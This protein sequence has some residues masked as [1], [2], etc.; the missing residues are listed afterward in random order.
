LLEEEFEEE[1]GVEEEEDDEEDFPS[2]L[3]TGRTSSKYLC[4]MT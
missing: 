2:S 1:D 4:I 3:E